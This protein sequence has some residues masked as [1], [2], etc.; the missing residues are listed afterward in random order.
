ME[1]NKEQ[2]PDDVVIQRDIE[3]LYLGNLNT[4]EFDLKLPKTGRYG[5][6]ITWR[7]SHERFIEHTGKVH[8]PTYGMGNR[9]F[10]LY[11]LFVYG[12]ARKRVTYQVRLLEEKPV[13]N[14]MEVLPVKVYAL[15]GQ[16]IRI[17]SVAIIKTDTGRFLSHRVHW[18]RKNPV[19][20]D[21]CGSYSIIGK[22]DGLETEVTAQVVV[23]E[24]A[25]PVRKREP[26]EIMHLFEDGE[27]FLCGESDFYEAQ[28]SMHRYLLSVDDDQMLY[29]F[30]EACRL[31]T[32]GALPMTGWDAPECLLK[33]H[34]TGHYL[35]ALALCFRTSRDEKIYRKAQYMLMSLKE[36]Q[37]AFTK[38]TGI[39][40]GFLSGYTEEQFD[41]LEEYTPYPQIWAPYYTLH[42]IMAGLLDC[43]E[44]A[45]L[46]DGLK[47]C[48]KIGLWVEKRLSQLEEE[49]RQRMWSIY[50]AGEFGGMN[51]VM[52]R[53][54]LLTKDEVF[55]NCARYFDNEKLFLP[56]EQEIDVLE[57]MH[58]NQHIP[59]MVGAMKLFEATKEL[60]YFEA[61]RFFQSCVVKDHL[62]AAGGVGEGEMFHE[63]RRIGS[64]LTE[65]TA[66]SCASYNLL[67]L[68]KELFRYELS[69]Q[70]LDDYERTMV[71]HIL[72]SHEH[73]DTGESTYFLPF[74]PGSR[75]TFERENSCC[76]GT[77]MESHFKH[78]DL[79][80]TYDR[81]TLYVNLFVPSGLKWDKGGVRA[82][83]KAKDDKPETFELEVENSGERVTHLAI[84]KP[85]WCSGKPYISKREE[86]GVFVEVEVEEEKGYL[87]LELPKGKLHIEV[88]F[89][90][91]IRI[92]RTPDKKNICAVFYGAYLLVALSE[93]EE[94]LQINEQELRQLK[95]GQGF[96][97]EGAGLR[98]IPLCRV[99][100]ERYHTYVR[101]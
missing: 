68:T 14:V 60:H 85:S 8:R 57:G 89:L 80:Y 32:K 15:K 48:Y 20:L 86:N 37:E 81:N 21:R 66:E 49:Q 82:L 47:I 19:I 64:L 3:A 42:K 10:E 63:P 28:E 44:Y 35:S 34:T 41:L 75:R 62:Y 33:G 101:I 92:E 9:T 94:L 22:L 46:Q 72:A 56:M 59:Q 78:A 23:E 50:I 26:V 5:S 13:L 55:L 17:P 65:H 58:A 95:K 93:E 25:R 77:G 97:F 87:F 73:E 88:S 16:E 53:L 79:I 1:K 54:Y 71:N 83:L 90:C 6:Q 61:A 12:N 36:C 45:G 52:A 40:R 27:S 24:T 29:N 31:D 99:K 76:H 7:S 84:R 69:T 39:Q 96:S 43:Y 70:L 2:M 4:V 18:T 67:K 51:E 38:M 98:W 11:A 100:D 30:R 91:K 74:A